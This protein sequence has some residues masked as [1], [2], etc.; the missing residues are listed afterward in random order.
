MKLTK[1]KLHE[2]ILETMRE[3]LITE[4]EIR[5]LLDPRL[6]EGV[7]DIGRDLWEKT[8]DTLNQMKGWARDKVVELVKIMGGKLIAFFNTLREKGVIGKNRA[9]IEINA[10][11]AL[12]TK[13]HIDLG[14]LILTAIFRLSGGVALEGL[15]K[16]PEL[17]QKVLD[18]L[19]MIKGGQHK[20]ALTSLFGDIKELTSIVNKAAKYSKDVNEPVGWVALGKWE[21]LGGLAEILNLQGR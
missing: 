7:L 12:L 18:I 6:D 9:K 19:E 11:K 8:K 20:E 16:A 1:E 15:I 14:V 13:D 17:L 21:E 2:L 5:E 4:D 3:E 10:V